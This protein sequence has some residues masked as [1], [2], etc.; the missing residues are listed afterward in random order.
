MTKI[1]DQTIE[2][3]YKIMKIKIQMISLQHVTADWGCIKNKKLS[4][5]KIKSE[6]GMWSCFC[7]VPGPAL[8]CEEGR[9]IQD[10]LS[11]LQVI[12]CSCTQPLNSI[13]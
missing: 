9:S 6:P 8:S 10:K 3:Q 2:F 4:I 1:N 13:D 5:Y 12:G 11:A 7:E